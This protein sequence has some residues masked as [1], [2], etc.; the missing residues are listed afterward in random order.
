MRVVLSP[1]QG[2]VLRA[3][4]RA[5]FKE[6]RELYIA[7][8]Y[9]THWD[10]K[11][12]LNPKCSR[13]VFVVGTDFHL[14][15]KAA[16]RNVLKWLPKFGSVVFGAVTGSSTGGFHPKILLWKTSGGAAKAII[17]SSNLSKAAFDTNYEANVAVSLSD[18]DFGRLREWINDA[19]NRSA[20]VN[21]DWIEQYQEAKRP[22]GK[23]SSGLEPA[24]EL[25]KLPKGSVYAH[26]VK[27]RRA[28]QATFG[29]IAPVLHAAMRKCASGTMSN[30]AFWRTFWE[31]WSKHT[32]R[33]QGHGLEISGKAANWRQACA[34]LVRVLD[35]AGKV[36]T[37]ALDHLVSVEIDRLGQASN[38][39]RGAWFSEM[40]CHF[41]PKHYPL[42]NGPV[43]YWLRANKWRPRRGATEGQR[44]IELARKLRVALGS[45]PAGARDLA[46]LDLAIW[47]WVQDHS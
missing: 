36:D 22:A 11:P 10:A 6:A 39:T 16:L 26:K 38:P 35:R 19:A 21:E 32:S 12:G 42:L 7:T 33:F 24:V 29:E 31:T 28:A 40:L 27:Q 1:N 23:A 18:K 34:A 4:Y 47:H 9:L 3:L 41:L 45:K 5:A 14:T 37:A 25:K 15:R 44:Y 8:A 43:K 20:P 46:E 30:K 13:V 2:P 17:G